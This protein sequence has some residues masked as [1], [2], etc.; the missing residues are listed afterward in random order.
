MPAVYL[1]LSFLFI[2]FNVIQNNF[3]ISTIMGAEKIVL[4]LQKLSYDLL[5]SLANSTLKL[6]RTHNI[7]IR[8]LSEHPSVVDAN[9]TS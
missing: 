5:K 4:P 9:E 2:F 7:F 3:V 6:V 8:Q 1:G